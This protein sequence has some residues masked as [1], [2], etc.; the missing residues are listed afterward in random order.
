MSQ[1]KWKKRTDWGRLLDWGLCGL[2]VL[3]GLFSLILGMP[4]GLVQWVVAW[5]FAKRI[6]ADD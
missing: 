1:H 2:L 5:R 4:S 3:G 6:E